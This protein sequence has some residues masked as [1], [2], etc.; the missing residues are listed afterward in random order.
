LKKV[1]RRSGGNNMI[2]EDKQWD[3]EFR[4]RTIRNIAIAVG[5]VGLA[6]GSYLYLKPS[7]HTIDDAVIP[8]TTAVAPVVP[9]HVRDFYI[10][11]KGDNLKK[12]A[13]YEK[14]SFD[15]LKAYN[16]G[17]KKIVIGDTVYTSR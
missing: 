1:K 15:S 10:A 12:I 8:E 14:L 16:P 17:L 9:V 6:V 7:N 2:H 5:V 11:K 13:K 3:K 4:N